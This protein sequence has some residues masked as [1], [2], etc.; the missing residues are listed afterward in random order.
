[1]EAMGVIEP[2]ED[3]ECGAEKLSMATTEG[4]WSGPIAGEEST[5]EVRDMEFSDKPVAEAVRFWSSKI[6]LS[7]SCGVVEME[8]RSAP[9]SS[10]DML[11][12]SE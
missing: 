10:I 11:N 2:E 3:G 7:Y 5:N 6:K 12:N 9:S 1:M 4:D 8:E